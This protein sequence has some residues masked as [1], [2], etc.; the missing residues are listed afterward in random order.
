[1][2]IFIFIK[3]SL[4]IKKQIQ[5]VSLKKG[6]NL[7]LTRG[8]K[9]KRIR[10][11]LVGAGV[12]PAKWGMCWGSPCKKDIKSINMGVRESSPDSTK[13]YT[14]AQFCTKIMVGVRFHFYEITPILLYS[15]T[16][17]WCFLLYHY[18]PGNFNINLMGT[19]FY[20]F[21]QS[22]GQSKQTFKKLQ[23]TELRTGFSKPP[24]TR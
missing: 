20:Q 13:W 18:S 17:C 1:M 7:L 8:F 4:V 14:S 10:L 22:L 16:E 12:S 19:E 3:V 15:P 21:S 9:K 5:G 2:C 11:A 23:D 6:A 24:T